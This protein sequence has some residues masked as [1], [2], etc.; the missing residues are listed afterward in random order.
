MIE[1]KAIQ[2]HYANVAALDNIDLSIPKGQIFGIIGRSGA[3]KSSLLRAINLLERPTKGEVWVDGIELTSLSSARLRQARQQMGMIFQHF[4]LLQQKTVFDN[5]ALPMRL[6]QVTESDIKT[7]VA[8]LLDITQMTSKQNHYPAQLSGGQKQRVAIARALA[9][10]PKILLCDE[11]TSALDPETT[12]TILNLLQKINQ[13]FGI[14]IVL[15]THAMDVVKSICDRVALIEHGCIVRDETVI[16]FF[17]KPHDSEG[18]D[19]LKSYL[20]HDI[21]KPIQEKLSITWQEGLSPLLRIVFQ[22]DVVN[23]PVI[24]ELTRTLNIDI[25]ILQGNIEYIKNQ[26]VGHVITTLSKQTK[27]AKQDSKVTRVEIENV[28]QAL[29]N[30]G[31]FVEELGYVA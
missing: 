5:V 15:I 19:F 10:N 28:K 30:H 2:K 6:R 1:L 18:L 9:N 23:Q 24:A 25:N 27:Q 21:P 11:A 14:T 26:P 13:Q 3:G 8:E 4:N 31:L 12:Q 20:A 17:I 7:R 16:D 22:G 29:I